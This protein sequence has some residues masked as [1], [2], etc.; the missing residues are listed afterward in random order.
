V[1]ARL[2]FGAGGGSSACGISLAN[3]QHEPGH[4][5]LYLATP[6]VLCSGT[7]LMALQLPGMLN[8]QAGKGH[9]GCCKQPTLK[10]D[11]A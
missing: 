6:K 9:P 5:G 11:S 4:K 7:I 2:L 1:F 3:R 8:L 10:G